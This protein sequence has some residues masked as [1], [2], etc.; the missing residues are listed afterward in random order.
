[1]GA[2]V[3]SQ[4]EEGPHG[5]FLL[6]GKQEARGTGW[7]SALDDLRN[8]HHGAALAGAEDLASLDEVRVASLGKKGSVT[9]LVKQLGTLPPEHRREAGQA[10]NALKQEV[11]VALSAS[12]EISWPN[13]RS[14]RGWRPSGST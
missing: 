5:P 4:R 7:T 6:S 14:T 13:A 12:P 1:M 3:R 9:E 10:F 2:V 8:E 11:E